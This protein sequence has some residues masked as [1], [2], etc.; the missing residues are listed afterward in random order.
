MRSASL[1]AS[2][3][4]YIP[5]IRRRGAP[6]S[7]APGPPA[8]QLPQDLARHRASDFFRTIPWTQEPAPT[9]TATA[10]PRTL[11]LDSHASAR[12]VFALI[13]WDGPAAAAPPP[14]ESTLSV[15]NIFSSFK[16]EAP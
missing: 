14:K 9:A 13:S 7:K 15:N 6:P 2:G 3:G 4:L 11:V 1:K 8:L 16:W 12:K 10:A 5:T